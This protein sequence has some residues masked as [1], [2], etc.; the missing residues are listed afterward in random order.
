LRCSF[1]GNCFQN[2]AVGSKTRL[3]TGK[4]RQGWRYPEPAPLVEIVD[5][6]SCLTVMLQANIT[7]Y[8]LSKSASIV[9]EQRTSQR[10]TESGGY[11]INTDQLL[12]NPPPPSQAKVQFTYQEMTYRGQVTGKRVGG[13]VGAMTCGLAGRAWGWR[14][15]SPPPPEGAGCR[16]QRNPP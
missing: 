3:K 12:H 10:A 1:T 9:V 11:A 5:Q 6:F 4:P 7:D 14:A 15:G 13:V 2:C 16:S 8:S